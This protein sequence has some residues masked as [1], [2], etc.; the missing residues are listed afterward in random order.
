[1]AYEE[2]RPAAA[3][4]PHRLTMDECAHLWMSGVEEVQSF[5]EE[6][7]A[8]RTAK[9]LL[10]VRGAALHVD[11]LEKTSGE[12]TISGQVA[13]LEYDKNSQRGGLLARLFH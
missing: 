9:G 6:E 4:T 11:K 12:L 13:S 10:Y 1:M 2:K 7:V 5:D 8:V 3:Q